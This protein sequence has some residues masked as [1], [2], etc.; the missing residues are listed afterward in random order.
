MNTHTHA[1]TY[2]S[3]HTNTKPTHIQNKH[4]HQSQKNICPSI[5]AQ[6]A[7][8]SKGIFIMMSTHISHQVHPPPHPGPLSVRIPGQ[9][10]HRG[11]NLLCSPP[12]PHPPGKSRL[13]C[14]N[15]FC[16]VRMRYTLVCP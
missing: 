13:T 3:T 11:R 5:P 14:E 10:F 12:S 6:G 4:I 7:L 9:A 1:H 2:T 15:A 8:T 16:E